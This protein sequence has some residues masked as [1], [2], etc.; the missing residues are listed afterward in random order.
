MSTTST[1]ALANQPTY[2]GFKPSQI[3]V[4]GNKIL[5]GRYRVEVSEHNV[6]IFD[7]KTN[8]WVHA[9]GDP[10]FHTSD[11]DKGQF[12]DQNL[13][14]D[15]ADGTKVTIKVTP[16]NADGLAYIESVAVMRNGEAV[17]ARGVSDGQ[18]GIQ[19]SSVLN[20]A[21]SVD[22]DWTDGTVLR[23]ANEGNLD[24][25]VFAGN[26]LE[27]VGNDPTQRFGEI[28]FDGKGGVSQLDYAKNAWQE[29]AGN[30]VTGFGTGTGVGAA[31]GVGSGTAGAV[32]RVPLDQ[33][34]EY[35]GLFSSLGQAQKS[36][37]DLLKQ[38]NAAT[39]PDEKKRLFTMY[40][41][42]RSDVSFFLN[43][44]TNLLK[45]ESDDRLAVVRNIRTN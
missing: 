14:L 13:T 19:M 17:V 42:A 18:S 1:A 29:N 37:Q 38:A 9:H 8:Q 26:N 11:G 32:T 44:I 33:R 41:E 28:M 35:S 36:A 4:E 7:T 45:Q 25:L 22:R 27:F 34:P 20:N 12:H 23:L 6:K 40:Q 43:L 39:D 30:V 31:A 5:A 2:A 16:K 24:D 10:H 15:L 3:S 21:G